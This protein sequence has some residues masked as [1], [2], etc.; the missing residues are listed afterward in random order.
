MKIKVT[1]YGGA[2]ELDSD[3]FEVANNPPDHNEAINLGA[4][5]IIEK[6]LLSA[7]DTITIREVE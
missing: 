4:S 7:G 5:Q 1:L 6:W 3:T 2:G